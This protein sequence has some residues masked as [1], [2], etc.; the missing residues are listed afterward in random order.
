MKLKNSLAGPILNSQLV[1][2]KDNI[3]FGTVSLAN[4]SL[5]LWVAKSQHSGTPGEVIQQYIFILRWFVLL[6]NINILEF[7]YDMLPHLLKQRLSI[8]I[9]FVGTLSSLIYQHKLYC[10]MRKLLTNSCFKELGRS[11]LMFVRHLFFSHLFVY[12]AKVIQGKE[13]RSRFTSTLQ[14]TATRNLNICKVLIQR[15][16]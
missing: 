2:I 11:R 13:S 5:C 15:R 12:V 1:K 8:R 9:I 10:F 6:I 3:G 14:T 7:K 4:V 16:T